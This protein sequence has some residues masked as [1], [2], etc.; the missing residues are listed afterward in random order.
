MHHLFRT[1]TRTRTPKTTPVP[2]VQTLCTRQMSQNM[3]K[4]IQ[5]IHLP[6]LPVQSEIEV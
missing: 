2:H 6:H 1:R 5:K 4:K 3:E